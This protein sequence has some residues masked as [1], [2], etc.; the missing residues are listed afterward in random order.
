M[1]IAALYVHVY[2]VPCLYGTI[3]LRTHTHTH[4]HT[5]RRRHS[6]VPENQVGQTVVY[7]TPVRRSIRAGRNRDAPGIKLDE[8]RCFDS[9]SEVSQQ[10]TVL[11]LPN[12]NLLPHWLGCVRF[13]RFPPKPTTHPVNTL[14]SKFSI[15]S[16]KCILLLSIIWMYFLHLLLK[17]FSV[18][19]HDKNLITFPNAS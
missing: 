2:T 19:T 13:Y 5:L 10:G 12:N 6:V 8:N 4:T 18:Y 3:Y 17:H 7:L 14:H 9:P 16:I 11:I 1:C 15:F